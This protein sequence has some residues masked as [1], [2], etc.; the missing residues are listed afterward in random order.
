MHIF[1]GVLRGNSKNN[2]RFYYFVYVW[3]FT[4]FI[5]SSH[6]AHAL[7]CMND[8][9]GFNNP[10]CTANDVSTAVLNLIA[11]PPLCVDGVTIYI[12]LQAQTAAGA[13]ARYDIGYYIALDGGDAKTGT[14]YVDY[15]PPPL[16]SVP[17]VGLTRI[18]PFFDAEV[19]GDTCGDIEQNITDW[20]NIGGTTVSSGMPGPPITIAIPCQDANSDNSS[21]VSVCT[22]W[23][24]QANNN[25]H[26]STDVI[27]N[28]ASK[29]NCTLLPVGNITF[30]SIC[31]MDSD[32]NDG[33]DCTADSCDEESG[34]CSNVAI[35]AGT[36]CND[37]NLCTTNDVC[38]G[39]GNL[40]CAGAP[41]VCP[42]ADQCN[43]S[44]C[45]FGTGLCTALTPVADGTGC[46]DNMLCTSLD[47]CTDGICNG[48]D[49]CEPGTICVGDICTIGPAC[50]T[51]AECDDANPCTDDICS[52][53]TCINTNNTASC[54]DGNA[55]TLNDACSLGA[56]QAG[57]P[58]VC[59]ALDQC[60]QAGV[61]D[62]D[63]GCSNPILP[64]N[65]PCNDMITCT[66]L[67]ACH[68]GICSGI[69]NCGLGLICQENAC[70][71]PPPC[72]NSSECDDGVGCTTDLC[73]NGI[74]IHTCGGAAP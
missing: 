62:P 11:G 74:C 58:V 47:V 31:T 71:A 4:T 56:C 22:T 61:C 43:T 51:N 27:P 12:Q 16:N 29:C 52:V 30:Q 1:C 59:M 60:H 57:T 70:V 46:D 55:C 3:I 10:V 28:T 5:L 36:L 15:L 14:C 41:V 65:T 18:S 45:D 9:A 69:N 25:C 53:G 64:E 19:N 13:N 40:I 24:N 48:T 8:F 2:P 17:T 6:R 50:I 66:S 72:M 39:A 34:T 21:D 7:N 26:S 54:D 63:T 73:V 33:S 44:T 20:R 42:G 67:D 68:S 37:G 23:D 38:G 35:G 49:N 32:C